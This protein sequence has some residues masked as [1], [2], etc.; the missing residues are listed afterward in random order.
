MCAAA[1]RRIGLGNNIK[2]CEPARF[3][4]EGVASLEQPRLSVLARELHQINQPTQ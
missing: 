2:A 3:G 4:L 1:C